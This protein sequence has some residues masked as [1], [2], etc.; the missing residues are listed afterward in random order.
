MRQPFPTSSNH[1]AEPK[2]STSVAIISGGEGREPAKLTQLGPKKPER[3][4]VGSILTTSLLYLPHLLFFTSENAKL[5]SLSV[6]SAVNQVGGHAE[7]LQ[8]TSTIAEWML[9][10]KHTEFF[11]IILWNCVGDVLS[12]LCG[13]FLGLLYWIYCKYKIL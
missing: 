5:N 7:M 6:I 8:H 10:L 2:A 9:C 13:H 4:I 12:Q 1:P 3:C 11:R